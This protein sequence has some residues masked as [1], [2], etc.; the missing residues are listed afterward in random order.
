MILN[1]G[2]K[3]QFSEKLM[4]VLDYI[5]FNFP[6]FLKHFQNHTLL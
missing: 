1:K 2:I 4:A 6:L 3:E 5:S